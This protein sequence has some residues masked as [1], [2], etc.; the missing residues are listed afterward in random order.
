MRYYYS[1][2]WKAL[3]FIILMHIPSVLWAVLAGAD[4]PLRVESLTTEFDIA[5]LIAEILMICSLIGL[6]STREAEYPL[7][8]VIVATI[9]CAVAYYAGWGMYLMG[10]QGHLVITALAVSP[11]LALAGYSIFRRNHI[12]LVLS[13]IFTMCHLIYAVVNFWPTA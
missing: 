2:D 9:L 4:D 8:P 13:V 12:A 6:R 3:I 11:C 5:G 1:F 7:L 10:H